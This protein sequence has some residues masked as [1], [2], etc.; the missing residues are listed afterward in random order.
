MTMCGY[1][2]SGLR[3]RTRANDGP[4]VVD[5]GLGPEPAQNSQRSHKSAYSL[6]AQSAE[7]TARKKNA[8]RT[9]PTSE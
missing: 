2:A 7:R 1:P 8:E 9:R 5:R 3:A 4:V 6:V